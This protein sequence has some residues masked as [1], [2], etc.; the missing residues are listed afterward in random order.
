MQMSE[1]SSKC[2]FSQCS[3]AGEDPKQ[4]PALFCHLSAPALSRAFSSKCLASSWSL[5]PSWR[6]SH[7]NPR[8]PQNCF[9]C[10]QADTANQI[11]P[12]ALLSSDVC[13]FIS[14]LSS[15]GFCFLIVEGT[16]ARVVPVLTCIVVQSL[17]T[18]S[19]LVVPL[20]LETRGRLALLCGQW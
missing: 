8:I 16:S 19:A 20:S 1:D 11:N 12:P 9:R 3:R 17:R 18:L 6:A 10:C 14:C 2:A 15:W 5:L 4:S 13:S 7:Q